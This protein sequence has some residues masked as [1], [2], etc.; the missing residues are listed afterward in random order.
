MEGFLYKRG[1]G[2]NFSFVKPWAYRYFQ[3]DSDKM[4]LIYFR[5]ENRVK[6]KKGTINV[7]DCEICESRSSSAEKPYC[8]E[9]KTAAN[10]AHEEIIT[11]AAPDECTL[12][13]WL[14]ILSFGGLNSVSRMSD[15][16]DTFTSVKTDPDSGGEREHVSTMSPLEGSVFKKTPVD[17]LQAPGEGV[18]VKRG[19]MLDPS[20]HTLLFYNAVGSRHRPVDQLNVTSGSLQ[21]C[22]ENQTGRPHSF[23]LKCRGES[24]A[25]NEVSIILAAQDA[26]MKTALLGALSAT[27]ACVVAPV[28]SCAQRP[29]TNGVTLSLMDGRRTLQALPNSGSKT[30][31]A[32]DN[33]CVIQGFSSNIQPS[34][35]Q[36]ARNADMRT[37]GDEFIQRDNSA[38]LGGL[39]DKIKERLN[40]ESNAGAQVAQRVRESRERKAS[41]RMTLA[42]KN[43]QQQVFPERYLRDKIESNERKKSLFGPVASTTTINKSESDVK[44]KNSLDCLAPGD[45]RFQVKVIKILTPNK[46]ARKYLFVKDLFCNSSDSI[47]IGDVRDKLIQFEDDYALMGLHKD[48]GEY[49]TISATSWQVPDGRCTLE[50]FDQYFQTHESQSPDYDVIDVNIVIVVSFDSIGYCRRLSCS[51]DNWC[52]ETIDKLSVDPLLSEYSAN[53]IQRCLK[54]QDEDVMQSTANMMTRD[55]LEIEKYHFLSDTPFSSKKT[56]IIEQVLR[57]YEKRSSSQ[58]PFAPQLDQPSPHRR[59]KRAAPT[60][61]PPFKPPVLVKS[62]IKKPTTEFVPPPPRTPQQSGSVDVEQVEETSSKSR[63]DTSIS[64]GDN[65]SSTLICPKREKHDTRGIST[66]A[67]STSLFLQ[68]MNDDSNTH[69]PGGMAFE[70]NKYVH[71][72]GS[73]QKDEKAFKTLKRTVLKNKWC[74]NSL[75]RYSM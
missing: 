25:S 61:P 33:E 6:E 42:L 74:T 45:V 40:K 46:R 8:F 11:L 64:E 66:T 34:S 59:T 19:F 17:S 51:L 1:R 21:D 48:E 28:S 70:K 53:D 24:M 71:V 39:L 75:K 4:E 22:S 43:V 30:V 57:N 23:I 50:D 29:N 67:D 44:L 63:P 60:T 52:C 55:Q 49:S 36:Q 16:K 3:L 65:F 35:S 68:T 5:V 72:K 26:D 7:K 54:E 13:S 56:V 41:D 38:S 47:D 32:S 12:M 14:D 18:W 15:E 9:I 73:F 69:L 62:C 31:L 20:R 27:M 10:T 2:R 58:L 37:E